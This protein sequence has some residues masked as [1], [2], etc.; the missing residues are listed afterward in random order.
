M[1]IKVFCPSCRAVLRV[2]LD[3]AGKVARCPGCQ[4]KFLIP[5][6]NDVMEET[7]S[8]W[9][10]QD[11]E[12]MQD[13]FEQSMREKSAEEERRRIE[14]EREKAA[15]TAEK[16]EKYFRTETTIAAAAAAS[17]PA[18][19]PTVHRPGAPVARKPKPEAP[20]PHQP[21]VSPPP[22]ENAP[23]RP[24]SPVTHTRPAAA[25]PVAP[26]Q[27]VAPPPAAPPEHKPAYFDEPAE[28]GDA[29]L[30]PVDDG[31][32]VDPA[33]YPANVFTDATSPHVVVVDCS[34][35]GVLLAFDSSFLSHP[36]FRLSMPIAC[37]FS[38]ES[39]RASLIARP[40][41]FFDQSGGVIRNA[42]EI[43]AGHE[44]HLNDYHRPDQI[45]ALFGL[46]P[47][48]AKPFNNP[49]PYYVSDNHTNM[50]LDCHTN[51]RDDGGI[52]CYVLV[53]DGHYA[54]AWLRNVN[55]VCGKE[56]GLLT[57]D[58]NRLWSV[59]WKGVTEEVRQRLGTWV[60]F[61]PGEVF[62]HYFNDAE[63]GKKDE[64]LAGVVLT[65]R[66]MIYHKYHRKGSAA[67]ADNPQLFIRPDGDFAGLSLRTGEGLVKVARFRIADIESVIQT[68]AE[69]G[70]TVELRKE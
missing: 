45:L 51:K 67:Y 15:K 38:G 61:E 41:A 58:V 1:E 4:C 47:K 37:A 66:R 69:F 64:G 6:Q 49:M 55:G 8:S 20:A 40:L 48:L 27:P 62:C 50:S 26:A 14:R 60:G 59:A 23:A 31:S 53:P 18:P 19:A 70:L 3:A 32:A 56:F 22:P 63:F 33:D 10:E 57:R 54:L 29:Q 24:D 42:M 28:T 16:M 12:D 68:M 17:S 65:D 7:V 30:P 25:A 39:Q 46:L 52:T 11:V 2:P 21:H 34:Q 9:I 43:E 5:D 44:R 35:K 36:G 13:E